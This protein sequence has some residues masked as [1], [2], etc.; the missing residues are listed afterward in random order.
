MRGASPGA[1]SRS[2]GLW[3]WLVGVAWWMS[4]YLWETV[5][6][7]I[8]ESEIRD[9]AKKAAKR[10]EELLTALLEEQRLTNGL[11]EQLLASSRG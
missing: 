9:Q 10:Q 4:T 11:L 5:M 1:G 7:F 2:R 8:T 6:G 3:C